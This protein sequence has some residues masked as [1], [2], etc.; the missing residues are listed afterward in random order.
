MPTLSDVPV[1]LFL[2]NIIPLLPISAL[3]NLGVMNRDFYKLTSDDTFW[4]R[5]IQSDYNFN[6]SETA[7]TTGWKFIYKRLS[8]PKIYVWGYAHLL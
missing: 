1:E 4:R 3:H 8:N 6:G 7:R 5:K 2:D